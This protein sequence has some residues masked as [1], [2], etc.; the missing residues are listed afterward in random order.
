MLETTHI[1]RHNRRRP[2]RSFRGHLPRCKDHCNRLLNQV[3]GRCKVC[4]LTFDCRQSNLLHLVAALT[5]PW[6]SSND[7][8]N[9]NQEQS[10]RVA[11]VPRDSLI[12]SGQGSPIFSETIDD[13]IFSWLYMLIRR[14]ALSPYYFTTSYDTHAPWKSPFPYFHTTS[15]DFMPTIYNNRHLHLVF[16]CNNN[17]LVYI[18]S[19]RRNWVYGTAESGGVSL[20][21]E[22]QSLTH[23][24]KHGR[25]YSGNIISDR[26]DIWEA[27][28]DDDL[29]PLSRSIHSPWAG[30]SVQICYD[31]ASMCADIDTGQLD[32]LTGS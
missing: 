9:S 30:I 27:A 12:Q 4:H 15:N 17:G 24:R 8:R 25:R 10:S 13:R 21:I 7:K 32:W 19:H 3:M 14:K 11:M 28:Y 23:G 31:W 16:L 18:I 29:I 26:Q 6:L 20:H 2:I 1:S 22:E 5:Q